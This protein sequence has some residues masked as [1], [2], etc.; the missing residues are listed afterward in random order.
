M[1]S[2][3]SARRNH[4]IAGWRGGAPLSLRRAPVDRRRR[5]PAAEPRRCRRGPDR[6]C[7]S[8]NRRAS[9]R[10]PPKRCA[11]GGGI[12]RCS[13][14][15]SRGRSRSA[16]RC[17]S[18]DRIVVR[19]QRF[20]EIVRS[21]LGAA[22]WIVTVARSG[23]R[24]AHPRRRPGRAGDRGWARAS[25]GV[26][27]AAP[28]PTCAWRAPATIGCG[29]FGSRA[30]A[31]PRRATAPCWRSS[32]T[33]RRSR[34]PRPS[35]RARA[36]GL[37]RRETLLAMGEI[38]A[39]VAHDLGNTLGALQVRAALIAREPDSDRGPARA[40]GLGPQRPARQ[41]GDADACPGVAARR[42]AT[43]GPRVRSSWRS[44]SAT[45][46]SWREPA[47]PSGSSKRVD[48]LVAAAAACRRSGASAP[49]CARCS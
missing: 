2:H 18:R 10:R 12:S 26:A 8:T 47:S 32:T 1:T 34:A 19:N 3:V 15:A 30:E 29:A 22:R 28:T 27:G 42:R 16:W 25:S 43:S 36:H 33:S 45:R 13:R 40:P 11:S 6:R 7:G 24:R 39:G 48:I 41:P 35:S 4:D 17:W 21:S 20:A 49:S 23:A 37:R 9:G 38:A 31:R 44:S 14:P 46:S 5:S